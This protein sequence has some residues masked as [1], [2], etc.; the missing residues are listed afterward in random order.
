MFPKKWFFSGKK[1]AGYIYFDY[2]CR[3]NENMSP[4]FRRENGYSFRI[5]SNEESRMHIHVIKSECEAKFW[6]EPQV[7]LA[8]NNGFAEHD[9]NRIIKIVE[10]YGNEF[11]SKFI[12]HIGK[13]VDD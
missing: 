4:L 2:L 13:R 7:E 5:Y 11:K 9:I 10:K 8:E 3:K 6:L 1:L 12:Q